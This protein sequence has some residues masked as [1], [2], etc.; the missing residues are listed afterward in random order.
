MGPTATGKSKLAVELALKLDCEIISVDSV[1]VY[2]GMDIGTAKPTLEERQGVP[3]HLIDILDQSEAFSTGE[4]RRKALDAVTAIR[5]RGKT[6]MLVGGTMLYFRSLLQGLSPLPEA[7]P[8]VRREINF[9]AQ[10]LGWPKMHEQLAQVDADSAARIHPNDPQRIQRALEVFRIT[11]KTLTE[12]CRENPVEGT[13]FV[14]VAAKILPLDRPRL[15]QR[16]E[17]RFR[18]MI[19]SGLVDEVATMYR[20]SDLDPAYPAVR[21]VGYRQV[22]AYLDGEIDYESMIEKGITATRQLA[23]R[24]MTWLRKESVSFVYDMECRDLATRIH[25]DVEPLVENFALIK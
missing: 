22:W 3:H 4:F 17:T 8:D 15:H 20:R 10:C 25:A 11:G 21:A 13:P 1:L 7:A 14:P 24:Q 9:E 2:R 19:A 16:I 23:K 12:L 18:R 6:P 5:E